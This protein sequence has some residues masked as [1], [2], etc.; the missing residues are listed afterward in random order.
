MS[1]IVFRVLD[2]FEAFA[3]QQRPLVLSEMARILDIPPSSCHG[4]LR[5]MEKRG[6][7]YELKPRAGFYPTSRMLE[8]SREIAEHDP[9]LTHIEP[10]LQTLMKEAGETVFLSRA[11]GLSIVYLAALHADRRLR[12]DLQPGDQVRSM[13]ASSAGKAVLATLAPK[14]LADFLEHADL[15]QLTPTTK[16]TRAAIEADLKLSEERGWFMNREETVEDSLTI[17]ARFIF[18]GTLFILTI[19]GSLKPMERKLDQLTAQLLATVRQLERR[20]AD[21][22]I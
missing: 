16:T 9:S 13:Y 10:T 22:A 6:Y 2:F 17:S 18:N 15:K 8:L 1:K 4:V 14:A 21:P 7:L 19:A 12:L 5:A 20:E 3:E 11:H